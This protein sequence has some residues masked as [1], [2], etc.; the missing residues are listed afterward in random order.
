MLESFGEVILVTATEW[1]Y[2]KTNRLDIMDLNLELIII[3]D[4]CIQTFRTS[5]SL[6][7]EDLFKTCII[8]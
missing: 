7:R 2:L 3:I 1:D 4:K 6:Y 8:N 5:I